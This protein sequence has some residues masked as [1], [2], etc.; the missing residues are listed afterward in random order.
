MSVDERSSSH[1]PN[2]RWQFSFLFFWIHLARKKKHPNNFGKNETKKKT[3]ARI[4][5]KK[6]VNSFGI[7]FAPKERETAERD[8]I[9]LGISKVFFF[10]FVFFCFWLFF[11]RIFLFYYFFLI[12]LLF[13]VNLFC[14]CCLF[15]EFCALKLTTIVT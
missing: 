9:S 15:R 3:R 4:S 6:L 8:K 11:K 7:L 2:R 14:W 12:Y 13:N 5:N 1:R 10:F